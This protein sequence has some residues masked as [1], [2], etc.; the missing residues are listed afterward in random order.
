MTIKQKQL[1]ESYIEK[2][3]L[4]ILNEI[5]LTDSLSNTDLRQQLSYS[6]IEGIIKAFKNNDFEKYDILSIIENKEFEKLFI[7]DI[8]LKLKSYCMTETDKFIKNN[9][10]LFKKII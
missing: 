1:L 10:Q 9:K 5:E 8:I 7:K 3:T 6:I 2:V 4:N